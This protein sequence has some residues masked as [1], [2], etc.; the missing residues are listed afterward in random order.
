MNFSQLKKDLTIILGVSIALTIIAIL[1][2]LDTHLAKWAYNPESNFAFFMKKYAPKPFIALSVA[3]IAWICVPALRKKFPTLNHTILIWLFAMVLGAGV[4]VHTVLK[5]VVERPRPNDSVVLNGQAPFIQPFNIGGKAPEEYRGVSFPSG[6]VA[7]AAILIVPFFSLRRKRP[8]TAK[9]FLAIGIF[10]AL[11][12]GYGRMVAGAHYFTDV[13]WATSTVAFMAALGAS[14]IK[15]DLEVKS[16]YILSFLFIAGVLTAWFNDFN[17]T[18][19]FESAEIKEATFDLPCK[20]ITIYRQEENEPYKVDAH[21]K[22][23]G[24]PTKLL[25]IKLNDGKITLS[26]KGIF[27]DISCKADVWIPEGMNHNFSRFEG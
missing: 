25:K 19:K 24:G 16:R 5:E 20:E 8:K 3:A 18:L 23:F 14:L 2:N 11:L 17:K 22:G 4:L 26:K 27:H 12:M 21:L 9:V 7:T 1:F 15:E 10:S 6:H 13:V